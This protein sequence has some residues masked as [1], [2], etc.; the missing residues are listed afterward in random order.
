MKTWEA[1]RFAEEGKKIR[2]KCWMDGVYSFKD[3]GGALW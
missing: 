3:G 1:L 2:R